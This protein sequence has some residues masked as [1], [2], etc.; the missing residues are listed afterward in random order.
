MRG[1]DGMQEALSTVSKLEDFVPSD[2][3]LRAVR[4]L[5]NEALIR[6]NGLFNLIYCDTGRASILP[7]KLLRALRNQVFFSVRS[8][9]QLM[10]QV[11]YNLLYRWFFGLAIDDEVWNHSNFSK[12]R[13]RLLDHNVVEGLF[14][15]VNRPGF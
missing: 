4:S 15:E 14:T 5:V 12:N 1:S 13:D 9:R 6:L 11:H 3:P 2:H 8:E 7:E 10:D